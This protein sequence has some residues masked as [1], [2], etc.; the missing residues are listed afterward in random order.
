MDIFYNGEKVKT[1]E[2]KDDLVFEI[3]GNG[4]YSFTIRDLAGNVHKF[5]NG[6]KS[7]ETLILREVVV[8]INDQA[9]IENAYYNGEVS[10][11]VFAATKYVTGSINVSARRNGNDYQVSTSN[12]YIFK[13]FGTYVVEVEAIYKDSEGI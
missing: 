12:P 7:V 9:P 3:L 6:T 5:E 13:D 8:T 2:Y 1:V 4:S 10:L 11:K